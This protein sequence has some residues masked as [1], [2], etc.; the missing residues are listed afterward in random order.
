MNYCLLIK[1]R[2]SSYCKKK[3]EKDKMTVTQLSL[4]RVKCYEG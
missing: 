1:I 2:L 4:K 3:C